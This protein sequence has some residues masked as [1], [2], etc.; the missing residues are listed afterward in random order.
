MTTSNK[1]KVLTKEEKALIQGI[2]NGAEA[3][4]NRIISDCIKIMRNTI[5]E[6][7]THFDDEEVENLI[8]GFPIKVLEEIPKKKIKNNLYGYIK[9]MSKNYLAE[10][11]R[12][13]IT[14]KTIKVGET[15]FPVKNINLVY[16][17][18]RGTLLSDVIE[19]PRA[20][21]PGSK[22]YHESGEDR[23]K[24][25]YYAEIPLKAREGI[26]RS[27]ESIEELYRFRKQVRIARDKYDKTHIILKDLNALKEK[28]ERVAGHF[29][30]KK[31][32]RY[33]YFRSKGA[34]DIFSNRN[35]LSKEDLEKLEEFENLGFDG[36]LP[37]KAYSEINELIRYAEIAIFINLRH[38]SKKFFDLI[39]PLSLSREDMNKNIPD[40]RI[41]P[42]RLM[43]AIWSKVK[44][45]RR[46]TKEVNHDKMKLIFTYHKIVTKNTHRMFLFELVRNDLSN[47]ETIRKLQ[48][49]KPKFKGFYNKL[50][51]NIYKTSLLGF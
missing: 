10:K 32:T 46:G 39:G 2:I 5:R 21:P 33:E 35:K 28:I 19:D 37:I 36:T 18:E 23:I 20:I 41:E 30:R 22:E 45:L 38:P 15:R 8:Y 4:K 42:P 3:A 48:Y 29:I 27:L 12:E 1:S 50:V 16:D 49:H 25:V 47:Y 14:K 31:A 13:K 26:E 51:E 11:G 40:M 9:E 7:K 34:F 43:Y 6:S 17:K 24:R 44:E